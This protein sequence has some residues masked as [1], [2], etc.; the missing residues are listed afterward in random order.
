MIDIEKDQ[1]RQTKKQQIEEQ[2]MY[3]E[4]VLNQMK[5]IQEKRKVDIIQKREYQDRNV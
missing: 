3:R 2:Q 4:Q 5:H 1:E